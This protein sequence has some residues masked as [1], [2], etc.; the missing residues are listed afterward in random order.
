[1][2]IMPFVHPSKKLSFFCLFLIKNA[3]FKSLSLCPVADNFFQFL[4]DYRIVFF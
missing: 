1:M 4:E 3:F 2:L